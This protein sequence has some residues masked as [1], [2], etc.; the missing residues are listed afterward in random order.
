MGRSPL[1]LTREKE[2]R[3]SLDARG[4]AESAR[5]TKK[6]AQVQDYREHLQLA[7]LRDRRL[8]LTINR[9]QLVKR[10]EGKTY[11]RCQFA[12]EN[13]RSK[14]KPS[15]GGRNFK[16]RNTP[17]PGKNFLTSSQRNEK[18][19]RV[20]LTSSSNRDSEKKVRLRDLVE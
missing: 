5:N 14:K 19:K 13:W 7:L 9:R 11:R 2:T 15:P 6:R 3:L 18:V 12:R 1:P 17:T 16:A 8:N 10:E 4:I 20:K